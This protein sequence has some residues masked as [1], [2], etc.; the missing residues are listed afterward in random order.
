MP[1]QPLRDWLLDALGAACLAII[2][3]GTPWVLAGMQ[4]VLQ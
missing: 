1:R 4:A 3:G 2:L